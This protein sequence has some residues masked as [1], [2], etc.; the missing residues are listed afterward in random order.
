MQCHL[1]TH[2]HT[3]TYTFHSISIAMD[4]HQIASNTLESRTA[5]D[6]FA[7]NEDSLDLFLQFL[8]DPGMILDHGEEIG[9]ILELSS[10]DKATSEEGDAV[11]EASSGDHGNLSSENLTKGDLD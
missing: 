5:L 3:H 8:N 1:H 10:K 6:Y 7:E 9:K 11:T 2:T 4:K